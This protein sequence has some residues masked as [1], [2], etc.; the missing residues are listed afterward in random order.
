[1]DVFLYLFWTQ[2]G[3]LKILCVSHLFLLISL[4]TIPRGF[5]FQMNRKVVGSNPLLASRTVRV[6]RVCP[7]TCRAVFRVF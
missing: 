4:D 5:V 6:T 7:F 3:T 2:I 1:M